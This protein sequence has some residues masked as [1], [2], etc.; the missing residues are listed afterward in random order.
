MHPG[1]VVLLDIEVPLVDAGHPRQGIEVLVNRSRRVVLVCRRARAVDD[2][3]HVRERSAFGDLLHRV[4][5]LVSTHV[6][7]RGRILEGS[8]GQYRRVGPHHSDDRVGP[9]RLHGRRGLGIARERWARRIEDH[10]VVV[11]RDEERLGER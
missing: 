7:H 4:V 9:L 1:D 11:L 5:E 8:F 10:V 3:A 2:A 6:V